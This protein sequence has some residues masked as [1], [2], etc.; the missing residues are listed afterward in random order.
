MAL[1]YHTFALQ[2]NANYMFAKGSPMNGEGGIPSVV[3]C[4]VKIKRGQ[5]ILASDSSAYMHTV[6]APH[7]RSTTFILLY[8]YLECRDVVIIKSLIDLPT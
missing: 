5:C 7:T 4:W 8:I 3:F 2:R 1:Q 6:I